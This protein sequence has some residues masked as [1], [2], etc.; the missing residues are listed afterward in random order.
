M[1]KQKGQNVENREMRESQILEKH[2]DLNSR[3]SMSNNQWEELF[4][5]A[6][7]WIL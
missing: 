5:T 2:R 3:H 4:F 1:G 7:P 6:Y